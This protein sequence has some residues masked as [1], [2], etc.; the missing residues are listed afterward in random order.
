M[1]RPGHRD[2]T[3]PPNGSP[4]P[5]D[6]VALPEAPAEAAS[7]GASQVPLGQ[8]RSDGWRQAGPRIT[9]PGLR[10]QCSMLCDSSHRALHWAGRTCLRDPPPPRIHQPP[11]VADRVAAQA[12]A[13]V[14]HADYRWRK[15]RGRT[16]KDRLARSDREHRLHHFRGQDASDVSIA[17]PG[18]LS[19]SWAS[20]CARP[21]SRRRRE[22]NAAEA[23]Y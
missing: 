13:A 12:R 2:A 23:A 21:S 18:C 22:G 10:E 5:S 14:S 7:H 9:R 3:G 4:I 15:R 11:A 20:R 8:Q 17:A 19:T 16:G 6:A 1:G